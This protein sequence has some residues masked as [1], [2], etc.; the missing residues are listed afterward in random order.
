MAITSSIS[1]ASAT[2]RAIGP[3]CAS[4]AHDGGENPGDLGTR[5]KVGFTPTTPQNE[6]GTRIEPTPSVPIASGPHP[7]ATAAPAPPQSGDGTQT[8]PP[9]SVPT[10]S[11]PH[12]AAPAA[13]AP[14]LDPPLVRSLFQGLRVTPETGL[15]AVSLYPDSHVVVLQVMIAAADF[16]AVTAAASTVGTRSLFTGAPPN[17]G[18]PAT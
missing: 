18:T 17:A 1:A 16:N 10:A 12:P 9:P 2:V 11:G 5:P 6:D 4:D 14:P 8:N 13:A 15:S 7:A 3:V